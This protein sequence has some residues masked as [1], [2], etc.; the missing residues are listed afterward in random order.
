MAKKMSAKKKWLIIGG[1]VVVGGILVTANLM[2]SNTNS[3]SVTT[4]RAVTEDVI[5]VVSGSGRIQPKTRVK[6]TS[7]VSAEIINL[8]IKEG[9]YVTRDQILVQLDSLQ[10]KKDM[11]SYLYSAN[12]FE[13]RVD[14]SQILLDQYKD[15]FDRQE[16]L[17]AKKLTSER[18]FKDAKYAFLKQQANHRALIQQNYAAVSRVEKARDNLNKTTIRAAM[19]GIVTLLDAEVGE[20]VQAQTPYSQGRTLLVISDLSEFEVE[21]EI[22]E[23]DIANLLPGQIAKVEI[24]A[25]PDSVFAGEVVEVGNTALTTGAGSNS[26]STNFKVKVALLDLNQRVRPGMSAT[27]DITTTEHN[28]VLTIPIQALVMRSFDPDSL[29]GQSEE[30]SSGVSEAVA[31]TTDDQGETEVETEESEKVEKKG[32]FIVRDGKAE[33]AEVV[34]GIADQKN[35]EIITGLAAGDEVITGSFRTLRSIKDGDKVEVDNIVKKKDN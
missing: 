28:D 24:D 2:Q 12:E 16:E 5:S 34:T 21:V 11:D 9:D 18:E 3:V 15:D 26:Q 14:G 27:V 30:S 25:F 32:V 17:Y 22:D 10:L 1:V 6:V 35:F 20:I 33:F 8:P 31:S 13:A 19:D 29:P 23:T 4:R 7:E